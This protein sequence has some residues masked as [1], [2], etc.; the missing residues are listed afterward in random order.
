MEGGEEGRIYQAMKKNTVS[1]KGG[2]GRARGSYFDRRIRESFLAVTIK[3]R[4]E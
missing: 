1:K 4:L 2:D 3:E